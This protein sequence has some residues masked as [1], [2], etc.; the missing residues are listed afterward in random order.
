MSQ[1]EL[2]LTL[3]ILRWLAGGQLA[4]RLE[5]AVRLWVL[6]HCL[7]GEQQWQ[8]LPET[9]GYAHIRD[10]LF[11][12]R[13]PKQDPEVN[14]GIPSS[15]PCPEASC[16]CRRPLSFWL[17]DPNLLAALK[18]EIPDL[19]TLLLSR[20]FQK[21][22]R[23]LRKELDFL[24]DQGWIQQIQANSTSR[25]NFRRRAL[26]DHPQPLPS[27]A[28]L[29][30]SDHQ[31]QK[32]YH[33]LNDV[34]FVHPNVEILLS[35]IWGKHKALQQRIFVQ[36]EYILSPE[37]QEQV[38]EYHNQL[39]TLW[40]NPEPGMIRFDYATR[41]QGIRSILTYPVCLFYA[42]R[43]KY[44]TAFGERPSLASSELHHPA[45]ARKIGWY[46]FRLDR[47]QSP[48]LS[49]VPWS[50][51]MIPPELMALKQRNQLPSPEDVQTEW[52]AAWGS[53]FYLPKAL[54]ILRFPPDFARRYVDN[55]E[56]H[57]TFKP[58]AYE[59]IPALVKKEITDPKEQEYILQVLQH[60]PKTDRYFRA[61]VRVGD[62]N[63]TMRLRDWRSNGEVIAPLAY[64]EQMR[65]EAE[66]ECQFYRFPPL[67]LT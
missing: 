57:P 13:H 54:L 21:T 40:A 3:E 28:S 16:I 23:T 45:G 31:L 62:T 14:S 49:I 64:R 50:D 67:P 36:F 19:E 35:E 66:V 17:T 6:L 32:I 33:I 55:T 15:L 11:S 29:P 30:L 22:H 60:R 12:P 52:E 65:Q 56:R 63:L 20:P 24:K 26:G 4:G 39:E 53:D 27:T 42:R 61:Y 46:N 8:E 58:I 34:A 59:R 37:Q 10:Q 43:A 25:A 1:F 18:S 2:P 7:Y 47:I 41:Q 38:D 9:F 44:L 5:R 48:L 51:P